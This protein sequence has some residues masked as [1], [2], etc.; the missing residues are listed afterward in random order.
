MRVY[1]QHQ[2]WLDDARD[3]NGVRA[4]MRGRNLQ[5]WSLVETDWNQA[6]LRHADLRGVDLRKAD[7][8]GA[9][10]DGADLRRAKIQGAD[11]TAASLVGANLS[12]LDLTKAVGVGEALLSK[13]DQDE[14]LRRISRK[15]TV[16]VPFKPTRRHP[17]PKYAVRRDRFSPYHY[18]SYSRKTSAME[19]ADSFF[20]KGTIYQLVTP[21]GRV[22]EQVAGKPD[23]ES[24]SVRIILLG[25]D[26]TYGQF[27]GPEA[28]QRWAD[29]RVAPGSTFSLYKYS[30]G[31]L[32]PKLGDYLKVP[33]E[34]VGGSSATVF[35]E[36]GEKYA[37]KR[38]LYYV[39]ALEDLTDKVLDH[40]DRISSKR[41]AKKVA[42][43][44]KRHLKELG[45]KTVNIVEQNPS[46]AE[47]EAHGP[48]DEV[49]RAAFIA[50][51]WH[52][53]LSSPLYALSSGVWSELGPDDYEAAADELEEALD[54]VPDDPGDW[55][56]SE[57]LWEAEEAVPA[58]RKFAK[59]LRRSGVE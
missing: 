36:R 16:T 6:D 30:R 32:G 54:K 34:A 11:F 12:G 50:R 8:S 24:D 17:G 28:A 46:M 27:D 59:A 9:A 55:V 42:A 53:G 52:G 20:E 14:F 38:Q 48:P 7:L 26:G 2:K 40:A 23:H 39:Q 13:G 1:A 25:E 45:Y 22:Q 35:I 5:G 33:D 19:A 57:E 21:D 18:I 49:V 3:P 51:D 43:E 37:G 44:M 31:N 56:T 29:G 4:D 15:T 47:V 10:L 41:E 58:L